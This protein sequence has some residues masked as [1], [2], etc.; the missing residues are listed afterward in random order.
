MRAEMTARGM[1]RCGSCR[2]FKSTINFAVSRASADGLCFKCR[3]C[4]A[5]AAREWREA[6]PGAYQAWHADNL[7]RRREYCRSWHEANRDRRAAYNLEWSRENPHIVNSLVARRN[8]AKFRATP[9]WADQDAIRAV[10]AEAARL[11]T[12]TGVRHEV[13][14]VY[15]I[16]GKTVCGLHCEANLQILTKTEN[17]RKH[18]R[19]PD[20]RTGAHRGAAPGHTPAV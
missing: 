12:E 4:S 17:I 15:P 5:A 16:Q 19:M 14:H 3:D 18:N 13:D 6:N 1:K 10:Y 7:E 20:E 11:T 9:K 2:A 8:A